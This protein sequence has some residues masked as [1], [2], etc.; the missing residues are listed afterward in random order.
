MGHGA[1]TCWAVLESPLGCTCP[2][3]IKLFCW[4][5]M[6]LFLCIRSYKEKSC[7]Q[8]RAQLPSAYLRLAKEH[9]QFP[10]AQPS[11][12]QYLLYSRYCQALGRICSALSP[13]L[14]LSWQLDPVQ[15]PP[16]AGSARVT[17]VIAN[18]CI[19]KVIPALWQPQ[20]SPSCGCCFLEGICHPPE[21]QGH[22]QSCLLPSALLALQASPELGSTLGQERVW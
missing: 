13:G 21:H 11:R 3:E 9:R 18:G 22:P 1:D 5:E 10:A 7:Q 2:V 15:T 17:S 14:E 8:L 12:S 6:S 19:A 20:L 16:G 4:M